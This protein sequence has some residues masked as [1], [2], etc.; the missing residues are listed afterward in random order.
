MSLTISWWMAA[1]P[2]SYGFHLSPLLYLAVYHSI[3]FI[4][5]EAFII[6]IIATDW[7]ALKIVQ[8]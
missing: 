3:H 8:I 5:P 1:T 6:T 2:Y 7:Q 4:L